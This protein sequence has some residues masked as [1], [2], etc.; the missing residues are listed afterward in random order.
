MSNVLAGIG[1]GQLHVLPDRVDARRRNYEFYRSALADFDG[2]EFMPEAPYGRCTRWLTCMTIDPEK[3]GT[4]RDA[5]IAAL[6]REDIESRPVWK[7]LHL[8]PVFQGCTCRGRS[9]AE[10][11]FTRGICL[12]SGSNLSSEDLE[13]IT[14]II[15]GESHRGLHKRE[16]LKAASHK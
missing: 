4:D 2:L 6:G 12:P 11:L 8:Q 14:S 15:I 1:R 9:V 16:I 13:R 10:D 3:F 5:I 7:P